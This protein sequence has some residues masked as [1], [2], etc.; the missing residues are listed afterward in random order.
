MQKTILYTLCPLL[1]VCVLKSILSKSIYYS[2]YTFY[3][4]SYYVVQKAAH[5][6]YQV[7][8]LSHHI[9]MMHSIDNSRAVCQTEKWRFKFLAIYG[10]NYH[11]SIAGNE[12]NKVTCTLSNIYKTTQFQHQHWL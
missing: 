5:M 1:S 8:V 11:L 7:F 10:D 12:K 4:I 2:I 3:W 9:L 6:I